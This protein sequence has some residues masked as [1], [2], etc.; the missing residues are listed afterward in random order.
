M[1]T[2]EQLVDGVLLPLVGLREDGVERARHV[3]RLKWRLMEK[4]LGTL[5]D[6]EL[7]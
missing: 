4:L 2:A 5:A 1:S 7:A 3:W 6:L